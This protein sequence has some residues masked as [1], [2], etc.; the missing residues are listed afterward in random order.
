M[1]SQDDDPEF[2]KL[3]KTYQIHSHSKTCRKV[4]NKNYRFNFGK[5][6]SNHTI[7][8]KPIESL[9]EY[10]RF[11]LLQKRESTLSK[12][13]LY[14]NNNLDPNKIKGTFD[15][16]LTIEN[17]LADL[18]ISSEDCYWALSISSD[19]H[20]QIRFTRFMFSVIVTIEFYLKHGKQT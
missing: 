1:S 16:N 15:T 20:Y 10:E 19:S 6:F 13:K 9:S 8:A 12:V 4:K 18:G 3:V 2:Y 7:I 5:F 14:I 11:C 17:I